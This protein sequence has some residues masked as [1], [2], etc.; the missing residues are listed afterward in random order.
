M[1]A[2][3]TAPSFESRRRLAGAKLGRYQVGPRIGVGGSAAVYLAR[4]T[5][6]MNFEKFVAIKVVHDHLSE[7]KE[8][9]SQFLDEANLLVRVAHPN[10]VQVQ[11]LGRENDTLFLAMEYLHG[12]PLSKLASALARRGTHLD[13]V[14]VAWLGARVAEGLGYA[15]EMTGDDGEPLAL[16][17]RDVSPQNVFLTYKGE[18]KLID[19]GIARAAGRIAQTTLGRVKGKFSYMAPEQVLGKEFDHRVDLFALGA[20]LYEVAVGARLFAGGDESE[21]LH[22]ILFEEV[23]DPAARVPG[24]PP[25]L[26][27]I[28]SRALES[29]PDKRYPTAKALAK[30]L[31]EFVRTSGTEDPRAALAEILASLF[32]DDRQAQERSIDRLR[33]IGLDTVSDSGQVDRPSGVVTVRVDP[34][35]PHRVWPYAAGGFAVVLTVGVMAFGLARDRSPE[36]VPAPSAAPVALEVNIDV[37]TQ[38]DVDA[39]VLVGGVAATGKPRRASVVRGD[40]AVT[41]EVSAVGFEPSKV[42]VIPDRDRTVVIPLTRIPEPVAPPAPSATAKPPSKGVMPPS[43]KSGDP[44]VTEYPFGKK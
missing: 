20:T 38:P 14:L 35:K 43:V 21:T 31:D 2:A 12:Q 26:S 6:P 10:I 18:V 7:E 19:F 28:L 34:D 8:F 32:G 15:H 39:L 27:K 16:V 4:M 11:E 44:L 37:T 13:A 40:A 9:I 29:E 23:P 22:K 30:D 1:G 5:G 25:A 17:H 36:V 33:A 3:E 42:L 24:F 41:I